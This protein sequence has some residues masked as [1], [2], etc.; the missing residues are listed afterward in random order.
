MHIILSS[1][2][3]W[4]GSWTLTKH[5][6]GKLVGFILRVKILWVKFLWIYVVF[7]IIDKVV[8]VDMD[9]PPFLD[10]HLRVRELVILG[11]DPLVDSEK[12]F[13]PCRKKSNLVQSHYYYS[14]LNVSRMT[15]SMY[16]RLSTNS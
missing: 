15:M 14:H 4:T 9:N 11:T 5:H 13:I 12:H 6:E 10:N 1:L 8:K 2:Y 7:G 16:W 3:T